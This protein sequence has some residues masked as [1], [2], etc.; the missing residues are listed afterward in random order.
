MARRPKRPVLSVGR[1]RVRAMAGPK[2]S[3]AGKTYRWRL[4]WY[5]SGHDGKQLTRS[6]GWQT[7]HE[8]ERAAH[9]LA[10]TGLPEPEAARAPSTHAAEVETVLDLLE[11][12][13]GYEAQREQNGEISPRT[14]AGSRTAARR[15]AGTAEAPRLRSVRL[16]EMS[17]RRIESH[18]DRRLRAGDAPCTVDLDLLKLWQAARWGAEHGLVDL[19]RFARVRSG[20]RESTRYERRI[21]NGAP[22]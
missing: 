20:R 4:E 10:A 21:P 11:V 15:L 12:W 13:L 22:A 6:I 3:A 9:A 17:V 19:S 16:D 8:A 7:R 14:A 2:D 5:P 1:V 18:R